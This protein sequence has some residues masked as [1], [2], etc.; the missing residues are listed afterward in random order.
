MPQLVS[1]TL[2]LVGIIHL[3]PLSGVL[4]Q[5][6]LFALYGVDLNDTNLV[7]L[8]RHRAVLFGLIGGLMIEA[9]FN[10]AHQAI[11]LAIAFVS[12][13]SYLVLERLEGGGNAPL[14]RVAYV[15]WIALALLGIGAVAF[16]VG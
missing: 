9:A 13:V 12:V 15:D 16:S 11:A 10:V 6:R 5:Q 1:V 2:L 8:M 4:G 14:K 7:I 3:L